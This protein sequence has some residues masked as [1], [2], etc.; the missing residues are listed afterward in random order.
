[1]TVLLLSF[2][3]LSQ[4]VRARLVPRP[5]FESAVLRAGSARRCM[6]DLL[7]RLGDHPHDQNTDC[8]Y[9]G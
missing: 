5:T 1:M 3:L 2:G 6:N 7:S 8:H 4:I 9:D